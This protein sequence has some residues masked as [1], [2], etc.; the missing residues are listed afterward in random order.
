[1]SLKKRLGQF[2]DSA[3]Q[4]YV[5]ALI[6]KTKVPGVAVGIAIDGDIE[7]FHGFGM[8]DLEKQIPLS[9]HT[10][11]GLASVTKSFTA[12]AI[13]Q[14]AERE[15]FSRGSIQS[16]G[17][18]FADGSGSA[19]VTESGYANR[20]GCLKPAPAGH[21]SLWD[22]VKRYLPE[23]ELFQKGAA[24]KITNHNFLSHTSGIPPLPSLNYANAW[25]VPVDDD[26]NFLTR[27]EPFDSGAKTNS[28]DSTT[29]KLSDGQNALKSGSSSGETPAI[30]VIKDNAD[31]LKFIASYECSLLGEPGE[32]VSYSNDCF[33]LLGEIVERV[34][35]QSFED[36]LKENIWGPLGMNDTF[37]HVRGL[38]DH[39]DI[40]GLYFRDKEGN[41]HK[42]PWKHRDVFVSSGS[43]KSSVSDLLKY[44]AMYLN[45]GLP[46][47]AS[48]SA[49]RGKERI[50]SRATIERMITPYYRV[51]SG[52]YY[53]YGLS[54]RPQY[55]PGITLVQHG[56]N[57]VG[58][59]S[60]IG[61]IPEIRTGIV[62]LS[63]Q[64]GFPA[65]KVW[66]AAA[67]MILGLPAEYQI[68]RAP[69]VQVPLEHLRAFTGKFVSGEGSVIRFRLKSEGRESGRNDDA[70][71]AEI[72]GKTLPVRVTGYDSVAIEAEDEEI[73]IY[74]FFDARGQVKAL[75][76]GLRIV[77]RAPEDF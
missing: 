18:G 77:P 35:G 72:D 67:N 69:T 40:Q 4:D 10:V 29:G 36:Y 32:Y 68:H 22:P 44:T 51:T 41:L 61:F 49:G 7:Y 2:D 42:A 15:G 8:A 46:G 9:E 54:V 64:S 55:R 11:F 50:A 17:A 20:S 47:G 1:M 48:S 28:R 21:I 33:S 57:I 59:A 74:F 53:A 62:V 66:F 5:E 58:V 34:T 3:F 39:K 63:N 73:P 12:L 25:S 16:D 13:N 30:P 24:D 27:V 70:L 26:G 43:I 38:K 65:A 76:H 56:G 75:R 71:V 60:Y 6:E 52:V 31:L 14:L 45:Y 23:F 19:N 37:I